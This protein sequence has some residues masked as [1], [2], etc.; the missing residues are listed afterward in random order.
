MDWP[1][2]PQKYFALLLSCA[3]WSLD[4]PQEDIMHELVY[5]H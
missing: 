1:L 3:S 2:Q 4:V 5:L